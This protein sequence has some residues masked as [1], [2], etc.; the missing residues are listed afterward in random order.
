MLGPVDPGDIGIT[1]PHEHL[2]LDFTKY[3]QKLLPQY[4]HDG[5]EYL[6]LRMENMD[7]IIKFP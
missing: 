1:L 6:E 2:F 3:Y 7:K 5:L 4:C